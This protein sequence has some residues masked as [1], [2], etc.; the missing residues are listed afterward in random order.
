ME[1]LRVALR[2]AGMTQAEL[3]TRVGVSRQQV[4]AWVN[5]RETVPRSK[6]ALVAAALEMRTEAVPTSTRSVASRPSD[7]PA[8][9]LD[10]LLRLEMS[11]HLGASYG[12]RVGALA[13]RLGTDVTTVWR[14]VGG[15][16]RIPEREVGRLAGLWGELPA[17]LF[18]LAGQVG[19]AWPEADAVFLAADDCGR[20]QTFE[21]ALALLAARADEW[22]QDS[23]LPTVEVEWGAAGEEWEF[24]A[25]KAREFGAGGGSDG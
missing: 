7:A 22:R 11:A 23:T 5:D 1:A 18:V 16:A 20:C 14:W 10:W 8:S 9:F 6:A 15:S 13:L 4:N 17:A 21:E 3:A 19:V 12:E 25:A 2:K 24:L